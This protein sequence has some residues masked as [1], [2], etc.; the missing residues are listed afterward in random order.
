MS[1]SLF[2]TRQIRQL[3][4]IEEALVKSR[5]HGLH[6]ELQE[7]IT[8]YTSGGVASQGDLRTV[9]AKVLWDAGWGRELRFK[10]FEEYLATI[11][12]VP[13]RP[14][15]LP[16]HFRLVLRDV[17]PFRTDKRLSVTK[18][19]T[20]LGVRFSGTD[21]TFVTHKTTPD[22]PKDLCWVWCHDGRKY[23]SVAPRDCRNRF[24]KPE[25]GM[26]AMT[27]LLLFAQ[28]RT[29]IGGEG[30]AWHAMDLPGST[31][32]EDREACACLGL[33]HDGP[34]LLWHRGVHAVPGY[35]SASRRE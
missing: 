31:L 32:R 9:Q 12:P 8:R 22:V 5:G 35:G 34:R 23:R 30:D 6:R 14:A 19:C 27:G 33:W 7:V 10:T 1:K 28:D 11:P 29:V 4:E 17:R 18:V 15:D 24:K 25:T 20:M 13:E 16:D 21:D 26:D 2:T 3:V